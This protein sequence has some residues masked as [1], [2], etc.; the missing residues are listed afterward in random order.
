VY[1]LPSIRL[2]DTLGQVPK[3]HICCNHAPQRQ[4]GPPPKPLSHQSPGARKPT[5]NPCLLAGFFALTR[6]LC[7]NSRNSRRCRPRA[8]SGGEYSMI[9]SPRGICAAKRG[10]GGGSGRRSG[11]G[12][13]K[14]GP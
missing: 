12:E 1:V 13:L 4:P 5:W 11:G 9:T 10:G 8:G 7:L 3:R 6:P 14:G 2:I